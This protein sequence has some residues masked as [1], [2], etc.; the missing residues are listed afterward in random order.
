[1]KKGMIKE[2]WREV[3][4][5]L[6]RFISISLIV[7]LGVGFFVGVKAAS[8]SMKASADKFFEKNNLMD[9][10]LISEFG[11]QKA[12]IEAVKKVDGVLQVMPGYTT[13]LIVKGDASNN[14]VRVHSLPT[15]YEKDKTTLNQVNVVEGRLPEKSGE[16]VVESNQQFDN[17]YKI[18]DKVIVTSPNKD[19]DI[20]SIVKKSTFTVVG[21]VDSPQYISFDR[22]ISQ[23]G[24]GTILYYM[25][26]LPE[27]FAYPRYTEVYVKTTSSEL[28][29]SAFSDAYKTDIETF[30]EKFKTLEVQRIEA[31]KNEILKEANK[32]L[33]EARDK[34]EAEKAEAYKKFEDAEAEIAAGRAEIEKKEAELVAAERELAAAKQKINSARYKISKSEKDL[35]NAKKQYNDKIT[36]AQKQIDEGRVQYEDGLAQYNKAYADFQVQKKDAEKQIAEGKAKLQQLKY[37]IDILVAARDEIQNLPIEDIFKKADEILQQIK[38][39]NASA[40]PEYQL[41]PEVI[42]QM[43]KAIETAK[44]TMSKEAILKTLNDSIAEQTK[45]Y[46]EG[47]AE[48]AAAEKQ[49]ADAEAKLAAEKKRLDEAKV[50][51]DNAQ[52]TLDKEREEG[53]KQLEDAQN[54]IN[55]AKAQLAAAERDYYA[56][57]AKV[58][59]GRA[60]IEA[61]KA[62]LK[63]SEE[64]LNKAKADAEAAF[65]DAESEIKMKEEELKNLVIGKWYIFT[66][67]DNPGFQ[68]FADDAKRIDGI[69]SVFPLFFFIVAALVC[70]TTMTRMVEEQ[71]TQIGTLKAL[72]YKNSSVISK[73]FFYALLATFLGSI[74][75]TILGLLFLPEV[76]FK[77]YRAMYMLPSFK[78]SFSWLIIVIAFIGAL[79]STCSVAIFVAYKELKAEPAMLMRPKAPK[80]GKHIILERISIL[81]KNLNFTSKVTV[82]NILR[83]KARFIMTV[84]GIAGCTALI[85]AAYGLKD[86]ISV[87]VPKQY[88]EIYTF[89]SILALKYDGKLSE[90]S[91]LK[92]SLNKEENFSSNMLTLQTVMTAADKANK[93][94]EVRLFVPENIELFKE[95]VKLIDVDSKKA[96]EFTDKSVVITEKMAKLLNLQR[97]DT[98]KVFDDNKAIELTI[99]DIAENYV[100]N[101]VYISPELYKQK[102]G[103]EVVFNTVVT[104]LTEEG[105]NNEEKIAEKW[106][107]NYNI[108]AI[109]FTSDVIDSFNDI[110]TS[111]NNIVFVMII[112]AAALAFIVLYNLTNIN[113]AER[114]REIATIKVLGFTEKESANYVYREN[115]ILSIIGI[116]VGLVL[117][118]FLSYFIV[119]TVEMDIV[120]FGRKIKAI[121]F[122]YAAAFTL[123]FT[124]LVNFVMYKR[125]N[126]I[127]MVESLKSIE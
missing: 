31:N 105:K 18:G 122:L 111:L 5:S 86:S 13:D 121:S 24:N 45:K 110:I 84:L 43:E 113:V 104:K 77:A 10:R 98:I 4:G 21:L 32:K 74:F 14:V 71:R 127:S 76:I 103:E 25:M 9:F 56:G 39:E 36:A 55:S 34:L 54:Q 53:K 81:W 48:I 99:T 8:P 20:S 118:I 123:I 95:Y 28:G 46:E 69:A 93:E 114:L 70:L 120:M 106:L 117:G 61:A 107:K 87:V 68:S 73:Y 7:F 19:K 72:G 58:D 27:D 29:V 90:M 57:K 101:Y 60:E 67:F 52:A 124:L 62:K 64:E 125:I 59:K 78:I 116:L 35:A 102:A 42:A 26:I 75:G 91:S 109:T 89:D 30:E 44:N 92:S 51:L 94:I 97:G 22:G 41:S 83:Y 11:F 15:A 119:S 38:D 112:C 126:N 50:Q 115:I 3:R 6:N 2:F 80:N 1:M 108:L 100:Y 33:K 17:S 82:R 63:A 49:L 16:C 88:G 85:L 12:D 23:V 66:R 40:P 47:M 96:M 37:L 79:L 65:K